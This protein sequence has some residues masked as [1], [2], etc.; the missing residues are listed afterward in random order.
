MTNV[1]E[2]KRI[3]RFALYGAVGFGVG[4][5]LAEALPLLGPVAYVARG[6][7][8][9]A[10]LGLALRRRAIALALAGGIGFGAGLLALLPLVF[11]NPFGGV[12][13][14]AFFGAIVGTI[15]GIA[16]GLALWDWQ[17]IIG[18]ALAGA[19]GFGIGGM[20]ISLGWTLMGVTGGAF[21]GAALGY[22]ERGRQTSA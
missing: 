8:G 12:W 5:L 4:G 17:K 10:A 13:D 2:M 21:L 22:L 14:D 7:L 6:A 19:L 9:G 20:I 1:Q 18:L 16:L 11:D 3:A 15:L